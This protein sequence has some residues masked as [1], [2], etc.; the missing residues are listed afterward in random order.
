[1]IATFFSTNMIPTFKIE[2]EFD[3]T[4]EDLIFDKDCDLFLFGESNEMIESFRQRVAKY[5]YRYNVRKVY[6]KSNLNYITHE[7][8]IILHSLYDRIYTPKTF[9]KYDYDY[10]V[11]RDHQLIK[12]SDYVVFFNDNSDTYINSLVDFAIK[13]NKKIINIFDIIE[14]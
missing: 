6:Y 11:E 7:Q 4:I 13:N 10:K 12:D 3:K 14:V 1:M 2:Y 8:D 5:R 9:V